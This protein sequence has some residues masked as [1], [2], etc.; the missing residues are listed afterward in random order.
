MHELEHEMVKLATRLER[1][2]ITAKQAA[3]KLLALATLSHYEYIPD[4]EL[5]EDQKL[6]R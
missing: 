3:A 6:P 4:P 5:R 2:T 1:G